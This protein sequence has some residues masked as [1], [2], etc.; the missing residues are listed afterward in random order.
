MP[1][2]R[3]RQ[4]TERHSARRQSSVAESH[5]AAIHRSHLVVEYDVEGVIQT[6]NLNFLKLFGY[7][8]D[9]LQGQHERV[10][11]DDSERGGEL[12]LH[13]LSASPT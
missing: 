10:L 13:R 7:T 5:L 6:A 3:G 2:L 11:L 4:G 9:D 1:T 12:H 8:L